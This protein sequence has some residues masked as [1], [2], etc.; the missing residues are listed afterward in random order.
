[1]LDGRCRLAREVRTRVQALFADLGGEGAA[2]SHAQRSLI[3]RAVWLE[4]VLEGDELRIGEGE[5]VDIAPH[6]ALVGSLVSI[7]KTLGL[8]RVA[9]E[10][11]LKDYLA[12]NRAPEAHD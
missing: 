9:R 11:R 6:V 2:L 8:K 10:A 5:G 12:A 1:V 4:M 7:Y 3:R